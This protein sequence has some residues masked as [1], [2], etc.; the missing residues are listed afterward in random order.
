MS[1]KLQDF[2]RSDGE[3]GI[4]TVETANIYL[5]IADPENRHAI[6]EWLDGHE[7]YEAVVPGSRPLDAD[8]DLCIVDEGGIREDQDEIGALETVPAPCSVPVILVTAEIGDE[9]L[10]ADQNDPDGDVPGARI[11]DIVTLP[12][13]HGELEWRVQSLLGQTSHSETR[14]RHAEELCPFKQAIDS[15]GHAVFLTETDGT[16]RYV[17][18]AFEEITGYSRE[19]AVGNTPRILDSGEMSDSHFAGLW[20]TILS[21]E[22]WYGEIVNRRKNGETYTAEQTIAPVSDGSDVTGFVAMQ[23][24]ITERKRQETEIQRARTRFQ[25]LFEKAPE[26]IVVHDSDGTV[27]DVNRRVV[28]NLGYSRDELTSMNVTDFEIEVTQAEATDVWAEMEVGETRKIEGT[29]ERQDGSTYPVEVWTN[30]LSIDGEVRFLA[31]G[32]DITDRK[33]REAELK[34]KTRA[35]EDAP[36]GISISDRD[37]WENPIIYT[38][39]RLTEM[40]GY[41]TEELTDAC[42]Q[43]LHGENTDP[44]TAAKICKGVDEERPVSADI[45]T[46]RKDGTEF[47]SHLEVSPVKDDAGETVNLIGFHQD[48]SERKERETQLEILGRVLRHNLR[49]DINVIQGK[50]D[51]IQFETAGEIARFAEKIKDI[52]EKLIGIAEKERKI[53][54]VLREKPTQIETSVGRLLRQVASRVGSDYPDATITVEGPADVTVTATEHLEQAI[55]ELVRNAIVHNDS[56]APEV[57]LSVTQFESTARIEVADTGPSIPEMEREVLVGNGEQTPLYH[58]SGL[59]LW[60]VK[61]IVSRSGGTITF[62]ENDPAGNIVGIELPPST[63][64]STRE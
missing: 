58:G 5:R 54:A 19:E 28:E 16:I 1:E 23:A 29:H 45:R 39:E 52:S 48:I 32:R 38:N 9:M 24:D 64:Q 53:T 20:D 27:L 2:V 26:E 7:T 12:L 4:A 31:F 13:D 50:A 6:R 51:Q 36:V 56:T 55:S 40:T 10:A 14:H 25:T 63:C 46:Y 8:C 62:E 44:D 18:S 60:L 34:V 15:S 43:L 3:S 47:W 11:D 33:E 61:L 17:N 35:I 49:N 41:S 37:R 59:G 30:K 22:V 21:G 42:W 57:V